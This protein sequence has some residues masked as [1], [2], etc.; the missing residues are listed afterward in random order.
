MMVMR[1]KN[2]KRIKGG[3]HRPSKKHNQGRMQK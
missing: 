3:G 1:Y 2:R